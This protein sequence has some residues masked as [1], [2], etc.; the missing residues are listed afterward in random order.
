MEKFLGAVRWDPKG[1]YSRS[2]GV[3]PPAAGGGGGGNGSNL[4]GHGSVTPLGLVSQGMFGGLVFIHS[5]FFL[6][7][8]LRAFTKLFYY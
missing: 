5:I 4:G 3:D 1:C 7:L 2:R 6:C 8:W